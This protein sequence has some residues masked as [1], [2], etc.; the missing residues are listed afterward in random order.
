MEGYPLKRQYIYR[1]HADFYQKI[2]VQ[3]FLTCSSLI[4]LFIYFL[5]CFPY[6]V[7][8]TF[9]TVKRINTRV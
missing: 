4:Y 2:K 1:R 8:S 9:Y 5:R 7:T 3:Q 6:R